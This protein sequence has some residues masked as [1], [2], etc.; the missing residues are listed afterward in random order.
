MRHSRG[1]HGRL[2]TVLMAG[3]MTGAVLLGEPALA[4]TATPPSADAVTLNLIK[5]LVEQK[6]ISQ[7]QADALIEQARQQAAAAPAAAPA[8]IQVAPPADGAIHVPYIPQVVRDQ[9]KDEVK[10]EVMQEAKAENW[11][12]PGSLPE[13]VNRFHFYGDFRFRTEED[14]FDKSNAPFVNFNAINTGS[15]YDIASTNSVLPPMYDTTEDRQRLRIRARL[16]MTADVA[17]N[18][19]VGFELGTGNGLNPGSMNQTIGSDFTYFGAVIDK[20]YMQY[21]PWTGATL[22]VG[23]FENP[24][25]STDLIWANDLTF[26]GVYFQQKFRTDHSFQPFL[27]LGA[28]PVENTTFNLPQTPTANGDGSVNEA[29]SHDDW[30]YAAQAGFD[31]QSKK[32]DFKLA[33]AYYHF[34]NIQGSLSSPCLNTPTATTAGCDTDY[35]RPIFQQWG[36][37]LFPIRNIAFAPNTTA[38][39]Q[40]F[41]LASPFHEVA[42]TEHF[43]YA[44]REKLH[45]VFDAEA[46][47]NLGFDKSKIQQLL[48]PT[49]PVNNY[50]GD[51]G[52]LQTGSNAFMARILVGS[53][54]LNERWQW[55]ASF[56]YKYLDADSVVDA[57]D[58]QDFHLGGTNAKGYIAGA[59]LGLAHNVW[60]VAQYYSA[61]QVTGAPLAIDVVHLDLNARF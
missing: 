49:G 18:F 29:K 32:T 19:V 1:Q 22:T 59:G 15:A 40:Y 39:P 16:G 30:L 43:D 24:W 56:T 55:N 52:A 41:G 33:A 45:I 42:V 17:D 46:E 13:W 51:T 48:A 25:F 26:D 6:L 8:P 44:M 53:P 9:I 2:R 36:N 54:V 21:K 60:A 38:D 50:A 47:R 27:T 61:T 58:D 10:Q 20:A 57:F 3:A 11:A 23:R 31:W 37:T 7:T 35:S 34:T 5:L 12:Q 4:Q 14:L 28:F